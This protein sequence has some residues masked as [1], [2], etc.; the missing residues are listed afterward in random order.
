MRNTSDV[1][2][3]KTVALL[4]FLKESITLRR[5]RI[6]AY[7]TQD[8]LLWFSDLPRDLGQTWKDACISAF[9][10]DNPADIPDLWLEVRKKRK[11]AFPPPSKE[12]QDWVPQRFLEHPDEYIYRELYE[13]VD[14]LNPQIT[15]L[16]EKRMPSPEPMTEQEDM[17][18]YRTPEVQH[19]KDYPHVED[20]WLDYLENEWQSWAL[21]MRRWK[22]IQDVYEAVDFMRRRLEE[23]EERYELLLAIGLLQWRDSTGTNVKRHLLTAPAEI[24]LDARRG[25]LTVVPAATFEMFRVE[26]DMLEY[27]DRPRLEGTELQDLLEELDVRAWD[28]ASVGDIL[29]IVANKA[30]ANAQVN[31]DTWKPLEYVDD[32]FRA[33]YAPALVLRERR[34]T[35]YE[36]LVSRLLDASESESSMRTTPPWERFVGEGE[37]EV[38]FGD[39]VSDVGEVP[40]DISDRLYFPLL[41]NEEQR[42]IAETL[43]SR[44]Y[45]LVKG[46]PGCGKSH[47]IA[48]LI[49]HLLATGQRVLVT[50]HAP[51]ALTV[52][53]DMLPDDI[54]N[55]CVTALGSS[56]EDQRLLEDSVRGILARKNEWKGQDWAQTEVERLER[57]LFRLES[58]TAELD[59][60]LLESREAE[61]R[62]HTHPWTYTGNLA[63]VARQ[64]DKEREDY[65]WFPELHEYQEHCP[66]QPEDIALLAEVHATLTEERLRRIYLEI[67]EFALPEPAQFASAVEELHVAEEAAKRAFEGLHQEQLGL[68]ERFPDT[69]LDAFG[70]FLHRLEEQATRASHILGNLSLRILRDCLI[71]E[72]AR[73]AN[74]EREGAALVDSIQLARARVGNARVDIPPDIDSARLLNDTR[75]RLEY[76]RGRGRN[77]L[78]SLASR[79]MR[80]TSYVERSCQVNG[81]EPREKQSLDILAGFL[82][83]RELLSRFC[84][85]WP[86]STDNRPSDLGRAADEVCDLIKRFCELMECFRSTDA[87]ILEV[88]PIEIREDLADRAR[89]ATWRR[90][91]EAEVVR[92]RVTKARRWFEEWHAAIK[93]IFD[94]RAHPCMRDLAEAIENRDLTKWNAAW[95]AREE[96]RY[97]RTRLEHYKEVLNEIRKACPKL[98]DLIESTQGDPNWRD[99]L[100]RLR[101]AWNW[102]STKSWVLN[103]IDS[104]QYRKLAEE[105]D[106]LQV[107][108]RQKVEELACLKAWTAFLLRL[109]DKTEQ[110]LTAWTKMIARIGKGTGKYAYRFRRSARRYLMACIAKIP[111]WIMPLHKLW[112]TTEPIPGVFDTI[113]VDEA[114]Q[115][116]IE[117][118]LL[119][120][121]AKRIVVVG[122][123]KQNSPEAI[124]IHEDD[125]ARLARNHLRQFHFGD[126]LR[127]DTSLYDHAERAFQRIVLREHFRCVPEI[128]RFSNDLCYTDAP[129]IPLRQPPPKRLP[130]LMASF[131]KQGRCEGEGQRLLNRAEAEAIVETIQRCVADE[132]YKGKEIGVIVLQGHAQARF[133]EKRLAEVLEPDVRERR[134]IRC[135]VPATFQGDERDVIF[136]SL[137]VDPARN[138]RALT[139]LEAQRRFNVAMSRARDQV[140]LFHSVLPKDLSPQDLR[141]RLLDYVSSPTQVSLD[142]IYEELDRLERAAHGQRQLG[143]QPDPYESWFE[144]D[145]ALELLRKKYR[146]RPQV[147]VAGYR[148]DLV[149]EGDVKPLAVECDGEF[150][151]GP[152]RFEQDIARQRQLERA[153]WTFVRIRE[154]EFYAD[155]GA[156]VS[157]VVEACEK[158][159]IRP[160][161][162]RE[163]ESG[164]AVTASSLKEAVSETIEESGKDET[165]EKY[166]E[167]SS[168]KIHEHQGPAP[169]VANSETARFP[170]PRVTPLDDILAALRLIIDREGPLT[171]RY[172]IKVYVQ[173]CPGLSR[174]GKTVKSLLNRALYRMQRAGEILVE[175]ELGDRSLESQVLRLANTPKVKERPTGQRD[176]I[177]IPPSELFRVLDSVKTSAHVAANDEVLARSILDYYG[178]S[179]LTKVRRRHLA[180]VLGAYRQKHPE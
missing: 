91:V 172:L 64:I 139:E 59:R 140:W 30:S 73:W 175:D 49:C 173:G 67:G 76:V 57:E 115:A 102:A 27:Q 39:V 133:I 126:L 84:S 24:T 69:S 55:L 110:N 53:R 36:E 109:D 42:R 156:A 62:S 105:R 40:G 120:L 149:V 13:L 129:L 98:A 112:E 119:L 78:S 35:A 43:R 166:E 104:E 66:L 20:A 132:A 154:S 136:L 79:T 51:K 31:E 160:V 114:S 81:R 77:W 161:G 80:E 22:G 134:K 180:K 41:A 58:E 135:G 89:R 52:L 47:T 74:L 9:L 14:I 7:G 26:L 95:K 29:R 4:R 179:R 157:R 18:T 37:G 145:V 3:E 85:L 124:G 128:I 170:D 169:S 125:I 165:V 101:Q 93:D 152:E 97:E 72:I 87:R 168:R 117:T 16:V 178:F 121:L 12:L 103:V 111:A 1:R 48:N 61:T 82:E 159:G 17:L 44:P 143:R 123:D 99:R 23:A 8:T 71:G 70:T 167:D 94:Q 137:V 130:P 155:R 131:V 151:H 32:A 158:L 171:K 106:Q 96:L 88:L 164:R 33:S 174:A 38:H 60:K 90:L 144:V 68:V 45:V 65:G 147:E 122:D 19:L 86:T 92:R 34:P 56:R 63:Q 28:K 127:P 150:W 50:A 10:A 54:R 15:V 2:K 138:F 46:P 176:L 163:I 177:D 142:T 141:R 100:L 11:P 146:I 83:I 107:R 75:R 162:Q 118:L 5:K 25:V 148:I 108:I 153:N 21:D 113:V 116:G 6:A